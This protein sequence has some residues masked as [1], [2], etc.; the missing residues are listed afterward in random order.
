MSTTTNTDGGYLRRMAR[1]YVTHKDT[2]TDTG[3]ERDTYTHHTL[4]AKT[5]LR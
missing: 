2:Q 4:P 5:L 3:T 1:H